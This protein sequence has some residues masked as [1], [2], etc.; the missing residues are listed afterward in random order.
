MIYDSIVDTVG[1]TPVIRL[2]RMAPAD[3]EIYVK[4]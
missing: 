3:V 1:N 4:V 2:G